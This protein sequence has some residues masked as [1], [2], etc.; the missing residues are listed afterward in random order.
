LHTSG[1][2]SG[3]GS[4]ISSEAGYGYGSGSGDNLDP[5]FDDQNLKKKIQQTNF[6]LFL[7]KNCNIQAT[8]EAFSPE[9]RTSS[10]SKNKID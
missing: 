5:G 3:S 8:G 6:L 2:G 9:N 10:T 4:S 7:I 1:Y